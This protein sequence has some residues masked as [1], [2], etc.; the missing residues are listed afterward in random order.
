MNDSFVALHANL[1]IKENIVDEYKQLSKSMAN[2]V[3]MLVKIRYLTLFFLR[4]LEKY[5]ENQKQ[6]HR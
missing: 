2:K 4:H 3:S 5:Y 1:S 6:A